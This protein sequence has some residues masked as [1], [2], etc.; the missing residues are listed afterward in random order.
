MSISNTNMD[1]FKIKNNVLRINLEGSSSRTIQTDHYEIIIRINK[2][3]K[4]DNNIYEKIIEKYPEFN[5]IIDVPFVYGEYFLRDWDIIFSLILYY[6]TLDKNVLI[7]LPK[8]LN[9]RFQDQDVKLL[10]GDLETLEQLSF[11]KN[12]KVLILYPHI[13]L[14]ELCKTNKR[15]MNTIL[16]NGLKKGNI[17]IL[18]PVLLHCLE[19]KALELIVSYKLKMNY[20]IN[21]NNLIDKISL[22]D[23]DMDTVVSI[24]SE[25]SHKNKRVHLLLNLVNSDLILL[26]RSIKDLNITISR[27]DNEDSTVVINSTKN[28]TNLKYNY[29]LYILFLPNVSEPLDYVNY[30]KFIGGGGSPEIL[31]DETNVNSIKKN[32]KILVNSTPKPKLI[33]KDSTEYTNYSEIENILKKQ[34]IVPEIVSASEYYYSLKPE[35]DA[36]LKMNLSN[37]KKSDY[38]IIRNYVKNKLNNKFELTVNT[39]Q[40]V[41][42]CSPK[43][44]SKKLNSLSNKISS[45]DYRCDCT[46]EIFKD[47]TIGVIVWSELF[48]NKRGIVL[49]KN[50]VFVYQTT[51]GKWKY[52]S[53]TV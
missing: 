4:I 18:S 41:T 52:S 26:E 32:L 2:K 34:G 13:I 53:I 28:T 45:I 9:T 1:T 14:N 44:R 39:C 35:N 7:I 15:R 11:Q 22:F 40:L 24:V 49:N 3:K 5:E 31:V 38:E 6:K 25:Y 48:S 30:F 46:C 33:V 29:D 51:S 36:I 21:F 47:Y 17:Q 50:D 27:T 37:L 20:D 12:D 42:P 19:L 10:N 43:D 16:N 8:F 23:F